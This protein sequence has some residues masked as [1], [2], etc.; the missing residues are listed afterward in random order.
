MIQYQKVTFF[1]FE[2]AYILITCLA[3]EVLKAK[4]SNNTTEATRQKNTPDNNRKTPTAKDAGNKK[5]ASI[6]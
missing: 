1:F 4:K 5:T 6:Q 3:Q 2:T